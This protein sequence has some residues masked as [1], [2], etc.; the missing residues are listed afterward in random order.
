MDYFVAWFAYNSEFGAHDP[1][2][3]CNY[4]QSNPDIRATYSTNSDEATR[5]RREQFNNR[6]LVETM[7]FC[8]ERA[9]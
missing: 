7:R 3:V 2:S 6:Y 4:I 1:S 5:L 8:L 9:P